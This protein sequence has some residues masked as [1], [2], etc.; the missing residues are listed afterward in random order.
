[1][2]D[3]ICKSIATK[4]AEML[5]LGEVGFSPEMV[6]SVATTIR[7]ML[8]DPEN[9]CWRCAHDVG[10]LPNEL[11]SLCGRHA[12]ELQEENQKLRIIPHGAEG[13]GSFSGWIVNDGPNYEEI[14]ERYER[15]L[16][17]ISKEVSKKVSDALLHLW[18][19]MQVP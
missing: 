10:E 1:M 5:D 17:A 14:A 19:G 15:N 7:E 9:E 18:R 2:H 3:D 8:S 4:V 12:F 13:G 16:R 6:D 11:A